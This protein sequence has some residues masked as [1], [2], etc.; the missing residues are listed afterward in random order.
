MVRYW[1]AGKLVHAMGDPFEFGPCLGKPVHGRRPYTSSVNL[2]A[3]DEAPLVL[4]E[5][6]QAEKGR[7]S[8]RSRTVPLQRG[9]L[10]YAAGRCAS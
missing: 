7:R 6:P 5:L 1:G 2:S 9:F 10:Q 3:R 8:S 4:S